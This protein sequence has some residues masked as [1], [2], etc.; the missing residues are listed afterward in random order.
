MRQ[1]GKHFFVKN[2][3]SPKYPNFRFENELLK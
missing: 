2:N 3:F 1:K